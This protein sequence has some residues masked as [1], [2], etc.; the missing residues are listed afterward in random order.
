MCVGEC[1][2]VCVCGGFFLGM[3]CVY[4]L[5]CVD[6]VNLLILQ[7]NVQCFNNLKIN[8]FLKINI[9][10]VK[11]NTSYCNETFDVHGTPYKSSSHTT[12]LNENA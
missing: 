10:N 9:N 5:D 12:R 3:G 6:M 7:V 8:S 11:T 1:V 4:H 2:C